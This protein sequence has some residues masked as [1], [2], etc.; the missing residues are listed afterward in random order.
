MVET[1]SDYDFEL[2]D[3][4][5]ARYPSSVRDGSRL[6]IVDRSTK[7]I[8]HRRF[9]E[10][11][12][13]LSSADLLVNNDSRVLKARLVTRKQDTGGQVELLLVEPAPTGSWKAMAQSSKRIREGME[14]YCCDGTALVV[15]EVIGDGFLHVRLPESAE[16]LCERLGELPLPPY[17]RREADSSDE[18]RYQTV[19]AHPEKSG[20]VAA[21]TAGLH[22][23]ERVFEALR[24]K[25]IASTSLTLHVGPGT[26]L[27]V[28]SESLDDHVMHGEQYQVSAESAALIRD[29][30]EGGGRIVAVGTTSVRT[31]ESLREPLSAETGTTRLFVR[32]GH[33]FRNVDAM[34]TN[35]HLPKST[36]LMLVSA[37][38]G[39][40]LIREAYTCA[41]RENYRF[42]SYGDAMLIV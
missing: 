41:I 2:P 40:S 6:M 5:V 30:K 12:D 32:P 38:A 8:T 27:P 4:L 19:Y 24:K 22:F 39:R 15:E 37:F 7:E 18:E 1:V 35:F 9:W 36:L 13:L 14:L 26:F 31:L 42:Y 28:R 33:S 3:S 34:I 16:V 21:P 17:L 25:G 20:S 29:T 23:T 11:P 10:L